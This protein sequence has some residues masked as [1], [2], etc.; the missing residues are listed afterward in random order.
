MLF[1]NPREKVYMH[2]LIGIVEALKDEYMH[3]NILALIK[4]ISGL[5]WD[6]CFLLKES[7]KAAKL[8]TEFNEFNP[9][10]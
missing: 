9:D 8:K 1:V 5:V 2:I 6:Y 10:P 4:C 7:N 3:G